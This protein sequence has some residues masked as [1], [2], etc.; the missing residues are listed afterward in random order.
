MDYYWTRTKYRLKPDVYHKT[1]IVALLILASELTRRYIKK[2]VD[3][4]RCRPIKHI[5]YKI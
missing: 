3:V 2:C 5:Q 1:Y 4:S